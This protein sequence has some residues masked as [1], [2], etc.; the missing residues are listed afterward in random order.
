MARLVYVVRRDQ[1]SL[2]DYLRQSFA[3]E[4]D[5]DIILDRRWRRGA[6]PPEPAPQ[7][8]RQVERRVRRQTEDE[9]RDLGYAIVILKD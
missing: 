4:S 1:R 6:A 9:L 7:D 8:R 3:G 2:Y 5:V